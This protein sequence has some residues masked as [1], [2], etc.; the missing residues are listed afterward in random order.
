MYRYW[1]SLRILLVPIIVMAVLSSCDGRK[2]SQQAL[3][4]AVIEFQK[5]VPIQVDEYFPS[6]Y[7]ESYTDTILDNGYRIQIKTVP[8]LENDVIL[9]DIK[10][11]IN[12]QKH[13]RNFKI[14]IQL[15][16]DQ[17]ELVT[18]H[19]T[20]ARINSLVQNSH[21]NYSQ[22]SSEMVLKAININYQESTV[23][24]VVLDLLYSLPGTDKTS[25]LKLR[26]SP[27]ATVV[28]ESNSN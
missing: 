22:F 18:E 26:L 19:F 24:L 28:T 2:S 3:K 11:S 14:D 12:F 6:E 9:T 1:N 23:D 5:E 20:K 21:G 4:E 16:M 7:F 10:D 17:G 13:Y 15:Q 8:D 27:H 25:Q